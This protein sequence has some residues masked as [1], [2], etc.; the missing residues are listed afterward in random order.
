MSARRAAAGAVLALAAAAAQAY[1][2]AIVTRDQAP[3]RAAPRDSAPSS[4][5]LWQ[6]EVLEVRGERLDYVQVWDHSRERGGFVH[7]SQVRRAA[8][9]EADA[10]ELLALVRFLR[11]TPGS[12]ALGIG[13]AAAYFEAASP[14]ALAGAPGV[15]AL[16]ALGILSDR[17]ARRASARVQRTKAEQAALSAHLDIAASYGVKFASHERDG[18]M[19]LCYDGDAWRRVLAMRSNNE[20]RA[21][22]ALALTREECI[23]P[24]LGPHE[25]GLVDDWR[26]EAL[27]TVDATALPPVLKNRVLMR[28]AGVWSALAYR[29]ARR[30]EAAHPAEARALAALD[31]VARADLTDDDRRTYAETAMRVSASRWAAVP[32]G[33]EPP[34]RRPRVA[35]AKG[36]PGETC[37]SLI[38]EDGDTRHPLASRC[39]YGVVWAA[40]ARLNPEW[41]ALALAV[42]QTESWRELWVFSLTS[43]GWTVRVLPPAA[44]AP[45][46]G[47]AEFAGWVPGGRKMLVAREA[48]GEGRRRFEVVA[49][50][51]LAA[52]Q[53]AADPAALR[54]FQRWQDPGWKRETLSLR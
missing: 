48:K 13:Y 54:A 14:E 21:R 29:R 16:D 47:Y 2:V 33:A 1:P 53:R 5:V 28:R 26:A 45:D 34:G 22:A 44:T 35:L 31:A 18:R 4:A 39:T 51:S 8:L 32:A 3:L 19:H 30:N 6:G 25:R 17:L 15:E 52:E 49:L 43:G 10:P 50:S 37:V 23:A 24:A 42:Q 12:E 38:D 20:Q 40:S 9:A 11:D 41:T 7:A 27:D 36:K 46:V